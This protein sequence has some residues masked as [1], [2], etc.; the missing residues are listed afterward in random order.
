MAPPDAWTPEWA[1]HGTAHSESGLDDVESVTAAGRA[2][3][4]PGRLASVV[5]HL[6]LRRRERLTESLDDHASPPA[7]LAENLRDFARLNRL[8]GGTAASLAA[9]RRLLPAGAVGGSV[10]DIGAGGA[11]MARAFAA[12]GWRTVA[13]DSHD[14]V[15]A[16]ARATLGDTTRVELIAADARELPYDDDAFDVAHCS[17]LVHHLDEA[18][19]VTA[20]AEMARVS[21]FGVVVNDLRRG[22][23]P[24]VATGVSVALLARA[25][26][27]RVDGL[28]SVRRAYTLAELDRLLAR[29]GLAVTWRTSP[30][31]PRVATAAHPVSS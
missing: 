3:R 6:A 23:I 20:L 31:M 17:L 14:A 29:A 11:D 8:P 4:A 13:A 12:A 18:D 19:A 15:L 30:L 22:V 28:T 2:Q 24:Y 7:E 27:T 5:G 9:I 25:R 1:Q 10:L 16:S 26:V 21:R